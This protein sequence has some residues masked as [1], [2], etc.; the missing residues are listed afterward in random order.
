MTGFGSAAYNGAECAVTAEA[1][2][3]NNRYLSLKVRLPGLLT[4]ME[5]Q[6]DSIVRQRLSR[7]TVELF[8]RLEMKNQALTWTINDKRLK[9]YA[10][11]AKK[12]TRE[13]G[14]ADD[15]P[16]A[17][18]LLSLP[19]VVES[20]EK[21]TVP[22]PIVR[23]VADTVNRCVE[24]L[25]KARRSEGRRMA[26][27]I[28]KRLRLLERLVGRVRRRAPRSDKARMKRL[29]ARVDELLEGQQKLKTDDPSLQREIAFLADR[30]DITEELDRLESHFKQ[31]AETLSTGGPIGRALDFL[32]QEM[33]RE[34]NTI[35]SKASDVQITQSVILSKAEL[36]K[37]REQV[38]NIE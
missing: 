31:F 17:A 32:I 38:Q 22:A 12:L 14:V 1:R 33:G 21:R 23:I 13:K 20:R 19:G 25:A 24:R 16:T 4:S 9:D 34:I 15:Q 7:G 36:E 6:I 29:K 2:S 30:S 3:V 5:S 8:V 26:T 28:G 11:A 37:I 10:R 18:E 35:G 27:A